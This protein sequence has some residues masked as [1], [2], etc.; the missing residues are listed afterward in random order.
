[1]I[2]LT[3]Q[4]LLETKSDDAHLMLSKFCGAGSIEGKRSEVTA[5]RQQEAALTAR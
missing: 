1:M 3:V 4:K 5:Q 2:K